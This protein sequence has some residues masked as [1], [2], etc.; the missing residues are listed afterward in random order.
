MKKAYDD[1]LFKGWQSYYHNKRFIWVSEKIKNIKYESLIEIGCFNG[2]LLNYI[3]PKKYYGFDAGYEKK[4]GVD[5]ALK[6][7]KNNKNIEI[8]IGSKPSQLTDKRFDI[9][10]SLE[11]FEHID[12]NLVE[13]FLE[14]LSKQINKVAFFSVPVERG[15]PFLIATCVRIINGKP[16]QYT[17][18]EFIN[19]I[20]GRMHKVKRNEHKGF[21]ERIFIKQVD[22]YFKVRKVESMFGPKWLGLNLGIGIIATPRK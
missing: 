2:R 12:V 15:L 17:F 21:D 8:K 9:L 20:I 7:F 3:K 1:R 19:S 4:D 5:I 18:S 16:K 11:T 13:P 22:K 14:K 10:V 6:K